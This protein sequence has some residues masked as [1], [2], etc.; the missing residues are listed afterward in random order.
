MICWTAG[1]VGIEGNKKVDTE[2]KMASEGYIMDAKSISPYLRKV[3][4]IN[5]AAIHRT[6]HKKL[7]KEWASE[8]KQFER[9]QKGLVC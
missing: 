8:W 3:L 6:K 5:L 7:K 4:L 2:A 1:H 9:G